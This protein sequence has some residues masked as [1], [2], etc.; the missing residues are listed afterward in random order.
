MYD[1]FEL[2]IMPFLTPTSL[3]LKDV[4]MT[5]QWQS[6]TWQILS[7]KGKSVNILGS[8]A[9]RLPKQLLNSA[10]AGQK[11]LWTICKWMDVTTFQQNFISNR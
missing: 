6:R 8:R 1:L 5:Y 9:I 4:S 7:A 2:K 10:F 11:H 3:T